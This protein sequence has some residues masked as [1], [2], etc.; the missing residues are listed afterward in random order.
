M[1]D[2]KILTLVSYIFNG[3]SVPLLAPNIRIMLVIYNL[4]IDNGDPK[5]TLAVK[6]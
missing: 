2:T 1:I 4:L 5:I 3:L 6:G